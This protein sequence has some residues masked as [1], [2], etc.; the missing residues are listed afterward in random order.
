MR[1]FKGGV[2]QVIALGYTQRGYLEHVFYR[3]FG[4]RRHILYTVGVHTRNI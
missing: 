3:G 1:L 2:R 4:E